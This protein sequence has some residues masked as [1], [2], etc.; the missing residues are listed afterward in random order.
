MRQRSGY[1][2]S[3]TIGEAFSAGQGFDEVIDVRSP[4]EFA[5]DHLP[6]ATNLPVLSDA[7]RTQIGTQYKA[8]S[9]EAKRAGAAIV[10]KRIANYL[11][12]ELA[13]RPRHWRPL[14]YCWRGGNRS[15]AMATVLSRVG[16]PVTLLQGGYKA[17]RAHVISELPLLVQHLQFQVVCGVTGSGKTRFLQA[18]DRMGAPILDLEALANHRGSILGLHPDSSQPSQKRFESLLWEKLHRLPKGQTIFVESESRKI[19]NVQL[20]E[21]LID[22]IRA[23][24]CIELEVPQALRVALL[25][26]DYR[27]FLADPAPLLEQLTKLRGLV[28]HQLLESWLKSVECKD[29]EGLVNSLL[30]D[31]YDPSYQRSIQRNFPKI[32]TARK[33]A[34]REIGP[35]GYEAAASSL[36]GKR[37]T[38]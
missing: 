27:H 3:I 21:A 37:S 18:L 1:P 35:E 29:W 5:D 14:I 12:N 26:E 2:V 6:G 15:G 24:P 8:D 17:Y 19:G 33:V 23:S 34:I 20:P 11:E 22:A 16:W 13:N 31:H 9:F 10:S 25:I 32:E 30:I 4:S 7:E 36:L 38:S 28:A